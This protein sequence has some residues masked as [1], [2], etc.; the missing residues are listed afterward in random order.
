LVLTINDLQLRLNALSLE[1]KSL[2][3]KIPRLQLL[4]RLSLWR[5]LVLKLE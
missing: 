5:E 4:L 2:Y 3:F 1:A